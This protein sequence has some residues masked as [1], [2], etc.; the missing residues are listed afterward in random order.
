[1]SL[2][3]LMIFNWKNMPKNFLVSKCHRSTWFWLHFVL[4]NVNCKSQ[5]F[6]KWPLSRSKTQKCVS[7]WA[8]TFERDRDK[9]K[10]LLSRSKDLRHK[11]IWKI[12][13][14]AQRVPQNEREICSFIFRYYA[15]AYV[16]Y[17]YIRHT[18]WRYL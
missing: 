11:S 18:R 6:Q 13:L 16:H 4:R 9:T 15:R 3:I 12:Y 5:D 8:S 1:M 14:D 7:I 17:L 10:Y 2:R